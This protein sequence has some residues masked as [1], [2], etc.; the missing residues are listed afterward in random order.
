MDRAY[1]VIIRGLV[2]GVGFRPFIARLALEN[3]LKGYVKNVGGSEVEVWVEGSD[4]QLN[5]FLVSLFYDKPSVATIEQV[6]LSVEDPLGLNQFTIMKSDTHHIT[7]SNIP[8][9]FAIC[10][11]CLMEILDPNN[12]RYRYPFNSCAWCGPRFSM[13]YKIP[14][15]REN[16]S[17][18]KYQLC[19]ACQAEY[20]DPGNLRRYHAQG[21]SCS[22][23]GPRIALLDKDFNVVST[24]D[25][26]KEA[27][28]LI[29]AGYIVGVK[30]I[31]GYH[32]ACLATDD[33]V[34]IE[35]RR[36]KKRPSKPFAVMGLNTDV[37][38]SIVY[39][40]PEDEALLNSP[41]AP[42][43]LLPKRPGS[44]VSQYVSPGLAHEGVF[45]AYTALHYLLLMNT[46]DKF[47]VMTSGNIHGEPMCIDEEC[48]RTKLSKIA[49]YFLIHD[50]EIVNRVDDSV[51]RKT[52]DHY[53]FIRRSRGYAPSWITINKDLGGEYIAFGG[54]ISNTGGVGF[55]DK[56]VLT[57]YIGD[58]D[59]YTAQV[60]LLRYIDFLV[61]N[62]HIGEQGKPVVA[63]DVHPRLYSRKLGIDYARKH[64]LEWIEVQHHYAHLL[65]AAYDNELE[66]SIVGLA[67]DG[68]GWGLD[69]T[70]WGGEIL[71]FDTHV[72][73]FNRLGSIEK[74]PLTSDADTIN[75]ARLFV[76][77]LT[78]R[79]YTIEEIRRL[80]GLDSIDDIQLRLVHEAVTRGKYTPA[81][82]TGRLLDMVAYILNNRVKRTYEGEPAIW[83]ESI[84]WY[85]ELVD[86][87]QFKI[88]VVNGLKTLN[89]DPVI[90]Y[91]IESRDRHSTHTLARSFLY[92]LGYYLGELLVETVRGYRVDSVV[93]SGG[94]ALNEFIYRGFANRLRE[95]GLSPYLPRRI[96]PGDGGLPF[97]Q[98]IATSLLKTGDHREPTR[99][100]VPLDQL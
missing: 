34:V 32:I 48:A 2:Q 63:V 92:N 58:L 30:G 40:T 88:E 39:M 51:I 91:L 20:R 47:L 25:P 13:L 76:G 22:E 50:R 49:D 65:G 89:Y 28:E 5:N 80:V 62:Y 64:G 67:I 10:R 79:G 61:K 26:I 14:Y 44:K 52:S 56:I 77:Y 100:H 55:E 53:V 24:S 71:Y 46:R 45:I 23:D 16:T 60:D 66:G 9:D 33:D 4:E 70:I 29:D 96:P 21:I 68:V 37:L 73:G 75:P 15:D 8:P 11:D 93:I 43:L 83:L 35:L 85:G 99:Y 17:M 82:S 95:E 98:I 90:D 59:S 74:I 12:R 87:D 3:G 7:R 41:H 97:G 27:S 19:K 86:I 6:F 84:A 18:R 38:K 69:N 36:R 72:Y 31:G 94:A 78:K 1:R 81:S 57:Q 42:I 54:D